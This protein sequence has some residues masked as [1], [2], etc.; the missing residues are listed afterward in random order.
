[1]KIFVSYKFTGED[2]VALKQVL[3]DICKAL[4]TAGYESSCSIG[5]EDF[6]LANKYTNKQI[7]EHALKDLNQCDV[8]LAF[9]NAN[10]KSEGMLIEVGYALAK[11]IPIILAKRK[12]VFT[13]S[14]S[15]ISD[16]IIEFAD[17]PDLNQQLSQLKI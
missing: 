11:G 9:I 14:L 16:R 3:G 7:M 10:E 15:G 2:P 8:L 1:M 12:S 4:T 6:F 17:L 13:N 5:Q